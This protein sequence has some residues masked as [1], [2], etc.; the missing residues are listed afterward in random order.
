MTTMANYLT[1]CP[2][3]P[4]DRR[5]FRMHHGAQECGGA[6]QISLEF[7]RIDAVRPHQG[8]HDRIR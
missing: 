6:P 5:F 3:F 7:A 2:S 8:L 4:P 1:M